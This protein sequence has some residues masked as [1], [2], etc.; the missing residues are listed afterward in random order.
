MRSVSA[1]AAPRVV[2]DSSRTKVK[3]RTPS[4]RGGRRAMSESRFAYGEEL[5]ERFGWLGGTFFFRRPMLTLT[6]LLI[7]GGGIMG[8][9]SGGQLSRFA[10]SM[11]SGLAGAGFAVGDITIAGAD[12]TSP[13]DAYAALGIERGQSIFTVSAADARKR[14]LDLPWV[15]DA[16]VRRMLP[17][18]L[19]IRLIEKRPFAL[20]RDGKSTV[21]IERSGGVITAADTGEFDHL[22]LFAGPG[23]P[24]AAAAFLDAV[25]PY[26]AVFARLQTIQR[27]GERRWDL[28]LA[29]GVT[30][31]LPEEGWESQL[32]E[33]ESL[34]VEKAILER[35]IEMIDLRYPD[36]YVFKL[37]NGDSRPVS[38]ERRA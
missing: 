21:V 27:M 4:A 17:G 20:W 30:V 3:S 9:I 34:I 18:A 24:E 22:P 37:H 38:R 2:R 12:R 1:Q 8:L 23:A 7:C 14:L 32:T 26:R 11:E 19:S 15:G 25:R 16:E 13:A 33:L 28:L 10:A 5:R 6:L 29:G 31:K 36:N 35:D